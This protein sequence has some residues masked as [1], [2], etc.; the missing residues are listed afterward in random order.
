MRQ[1]QFVVA[2]GIHQGVRQD[3]QPLERLLGVDR[4]RQLADVRI[5]PPRVEEG[6]GEPV[7]VVDEGV[8][9]RVREVAVLDVAEGAELRPVAMRIVLVELPAVFVLDPLEAAAA[10]V[11]ESGRLIRSVRH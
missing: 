11:G 9:L 2:A 4:P 6:G 8:E 10:R 1:R 5:N 3:R 7:G